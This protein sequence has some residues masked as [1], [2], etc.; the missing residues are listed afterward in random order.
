M[1]REEGEREP[2]AEEKEGEEK[3]ERRKEERIRQERERKT[4]QILLSLLL[5]RSISLP[6]SFQFFSLSLSFLQSFQFFSFYHSFQFSRS[7]THSLSKKRQKV[8]CVLVDWLLA[9]TSLGEEEKSCLVTGLKFG[10]L[11]LSFDSF[12]R[13]P[14][15]FMSFTLRVLE[16]DCGWMIPHGLR[17][18]RSEQDTTREERDS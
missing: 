9:D 6:R 16:E 2:G 4:A 7:L 3:E 13:L 18:H 11:F 5:S 8:S 15:C 12:L 1:Q 10:Y 17:S 14:C